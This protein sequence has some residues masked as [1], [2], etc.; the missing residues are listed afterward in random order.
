MTKRTLQGGPWAGEKITFHD[1]RPYMDLEDSR[2]GEYLGRY[3][4]IDVEQKNRTIKKVLWE[5]PRRESAVERY[6]RLRRRF[7]QCAG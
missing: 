5:E 1:E 2:S 3:V 6:A 4:V 7:L